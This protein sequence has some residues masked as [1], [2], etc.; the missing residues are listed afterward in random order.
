[1]L[2]DLEQVKVQA[3]SLEDRPP[4]RDL[5]EGIRAA[6]EGSKVVELDAH[7]DRH[8]APGRARGVYLSLRQ[9]VGAAAAVVL[10]TGGAAW[11]LARAT[12]S[13]PTPAMASSQLSP[14]DQAIRQVALSDPQLTEFADEVQ[15]LE[16]VL[17]VEAHRLD[18]N[19]IRILE[20]NLEIID[21]A[22]QESLDALA[23][24]P[25][26]A[27][28]ENHLRTSVERKVDYLRQA[29]TLLDLTD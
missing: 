10:I 28:V 9:L 7:R 24:D 15:R 21:R 25:G 20:K 22:I 1:V 29:A 27:F 8:A 11:S 23:V 5:W 6:I 19:T 18:P 16:Q 2:D 26:N 14:T 4:A 17:E 13:A 3:R 12:G